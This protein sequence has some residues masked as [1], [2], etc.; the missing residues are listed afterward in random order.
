MDAHTLLMR[1]VDLQDLDHDVNRMQ[2]EIPNLQPQL[3]APRSSYL[4]ELFFCIE[5]GES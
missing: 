1:V 2:V 3:N 4:G 5:G